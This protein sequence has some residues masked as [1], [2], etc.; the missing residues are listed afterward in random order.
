MLGLIFHTLEFLF[1]HV[2]ITLVDRVSNLPRNS[3]PPDLMRLYPEALVKEHL[4]LRIDFDEIS[5]KLV[6]EQEF[7]AKDL[8]TYRLKLD[9]ADRDL[10]RLSNP[11]WYERPEI[12]R[13]LGFGLGVILT[14]ATVFAVN[15]AAR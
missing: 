7:H 12:N 9:A 3:T 13:W 15:Q 11:P 10:A 6:I 1:Y 4:R 8:A 14:V 5:R 2:L